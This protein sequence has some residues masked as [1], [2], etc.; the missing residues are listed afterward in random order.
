VE[1]SVAYTLSQ[2]PYGKP[3]GILTKLAA[4]GGSTILYSFLWMAFENSV[5]YDCMRPIGR[6]QN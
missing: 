5:E 3:A 4:C 2:L 1:F 6:I